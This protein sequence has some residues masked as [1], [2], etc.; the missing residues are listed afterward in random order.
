[1]ITERVLRKHRWILGEEDI[2][3]LPRYDHRTGPQ[4]AQV[5]TRRRGH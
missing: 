2:D 1:M 3:H 4:E 5:E